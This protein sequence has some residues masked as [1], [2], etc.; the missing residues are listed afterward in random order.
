MTDEA[1][2]VHESGKPINVEAGIY[3]GTVNAIED[4]IGN[5]GPQWRYEL[6]LDDF[7]EEMPWAWA[8]TKN[9]L[10]TKT[11]NYRWVTALLGRPL[12][13]N[14]KVVKAQLIGLPCNIIIKEE[15]D[16]ERTSGFRRFVD[17]IIRVKT[18]GKAVVGTVIDPPRP[19]A[20][21]DDKCFCGKPVHTYSA[22]G[23]PLCQKH[24]AEASE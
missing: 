9:G 10:G 12:A 18:A 5:Y 8:S 6:R 22:D 17:D 4:T 11:K 19:A 2:E 15:A 23:R 1:L 3:P 24:A 14:E 16:A 7:P 20:P 13:L 21:L